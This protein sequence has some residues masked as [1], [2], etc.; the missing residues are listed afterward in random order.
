MPSGAADAAA[1]FAEH[2]VQRKLS[3]IINEMV[4][5]R[6]VE[7][8]RW[9]SRRLRTESKGVSASG[10][11]PLLDAA[12]GR[13]AFGT[14]HEKTWGYVLGLQAPPAAGAAAAPP[15]KGTAPRSS[16]GNNQQKKPVELVIEGLGS[17]V[18]LSIRERRQ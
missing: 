14:E 1:Y 6:P 10:T 18:L 5:T 12:A 11:V 15:A 17:G 2:D 7:A 9:L 3:S 16:S 8:T 4:A 13:D